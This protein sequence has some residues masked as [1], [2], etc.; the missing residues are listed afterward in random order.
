VIAALAMPSFQKSIFSDFGQVKHVD[1]VKRL[2][3]GL[4]IDNGKLG[5]VEGYLRSLQALVPLCTSAVELTYVAEIRGLIEL[6]CEGNL[7]GE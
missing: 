6:V 5:V 4:E 7:E 2:V 1:S 3:D